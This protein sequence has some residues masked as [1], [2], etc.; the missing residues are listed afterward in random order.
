MELGDVFNLDE[1]GTKYISEHS[2]EFHKLK[3]KGEEGIM[4]SAYSSTFSISVEYAKQLIEEGYLEEVDQDKK[5]FVNIFDEINTLIEKYT[6][7]LES[8]DADYKDC[9]ECIKLEKRVVLT[10]LITVLTHL[11]G[12]KK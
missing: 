11:Q 1:T 7:E 10:N 5:V 6:N 12:L 2:E 8:I 9:P 4:T 3:E